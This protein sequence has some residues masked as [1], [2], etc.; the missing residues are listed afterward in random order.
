MN[1]NDYS[2]RFEPHFSE[3]RVYIVG[4][5]RQLLPNLRFLFYH[6]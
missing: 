4:G 3:D 6:L 5:F 1:V 2:V